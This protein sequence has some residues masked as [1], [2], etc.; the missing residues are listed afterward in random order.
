MILLIQCWATPPS[1]NSSTLLGEPLSGAEA[2]AGAAP[3]YDRY[4][5]FKFPVHFDTEG[6]EENNGISPS[7]SVG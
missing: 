7:T 4:F 2:N 5:A 1:A 6:T 3:S